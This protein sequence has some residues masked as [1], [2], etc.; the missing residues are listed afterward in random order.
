ML[1]NVVLIALDF[2][3]LKIKEKLFLIVTL[4][5]GYITATTDNIFTSESFNDSPGKPKIFIR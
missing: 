3:Q 5:N 2:H 4:L 1:F